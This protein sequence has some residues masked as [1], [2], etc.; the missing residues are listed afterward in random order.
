[1]P[2]D[3]AT[4]VNFFGT[5][6]LGGLLGVAIKSW[7]DYRLKKNH[8]L[9]E[10]RV[11]AYSKIMSRVLNMGMDPDVFKVPAPMK[12]VRVNQVF[13]EVSLLAGKDLLESIQGYIPKVC[14]YHDAL[15]ANNDVLGMKIHA[16]LVVLIE[17]MCEQ[18]R[19]ELMI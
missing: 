7:I 12:F 11:S 19:K 4:I 2:G 6:G 5:L 3:L 13:S 8:I 9:L 1:M 17:K 10:A 14:E 15:N 18:M 16:E